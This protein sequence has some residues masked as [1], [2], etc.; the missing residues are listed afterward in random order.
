MDELTQEIVR[1]LLDYDPETGKAFWKKRGVHLFSDGKQSSQWNCDRWNSRMAGRE[2]TCQSHGYLVAT[3]NRKKVRLHRLIWLWWYGEWPDDCV[4]H[5][6]GIRSDNRIENLRNATHQQNSRNQK[7]PI[8]NTSGAIGVRLRKD[9]NR[10]QARIKIE[11]K[12]IPIGYFDTKEEAIAAR[13][14]KQIELGFTPEHG[15]L[16]D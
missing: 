2:I 10:W 1:E 4:D 12:E 3:L 16:I 13:L 8:T 9:S 14:K 5:K 7:L 15:R 11:N 6:N